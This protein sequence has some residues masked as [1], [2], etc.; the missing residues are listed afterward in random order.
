M[1]L[2]ASLAAP[3]LAQPDWTQPI[4]T[5]PTPG[6]QQQRWQRSRTRVNVNLNLSVPSIAPGIINP[7]LPIQ[8]GPEAGRDLDGQVIYPAIAEVDG[9][10]MPGKTKA[11]FTTAWVGYGGIEREVSRF[12][13]ISGPGYRWVEYSPMTPMPSQAVVVGPD[14]DGTPLYIAR[15]QYMGTWVAGKYRQGAQSSLLPFA[16]RERDCYRFQL[17]VRD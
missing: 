16:G 12:Q 5:R 3:A 13:V 4:W 11:P 8:A 7:S 10:L 17:L 1:V 9:R 6:V 2:T 15:G 14:Q